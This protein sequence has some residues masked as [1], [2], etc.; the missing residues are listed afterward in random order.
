M[1][2]LCASAKLE[3]KAYGSGQTC[4]TSNGANSPFA[5]FS[6]GRITGHFLVI[7]ASQSNVEAYVKNVKSKTLK[8]PDLRDGVAGAVLMV[9]TNNNFAGESP[10]TRSDD[11]ALASPGVGVL[12]TGQVTHE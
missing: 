12:A 4:G 6:C 11:A 3:V 8:M 7:C 9:D 2:P 10:E 5:R 1:L